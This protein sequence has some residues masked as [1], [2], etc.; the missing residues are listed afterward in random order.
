[1]VICQR[2]ILRVIRTKSEYIKFISY[3]DANK[4]ID[5]LFESIRLR[6]QDNLGGSMRGSDFFYSDQF[7]YYKC[8]KVNFR[9]GGSCIDSPDWIKK[10]KSNNKSEK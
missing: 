3:N 2:V 5:E 8:H 4:V 7:M 9:S 6:C 10:E 1:M